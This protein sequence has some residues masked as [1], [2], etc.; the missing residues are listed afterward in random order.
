MH[1]PILKICVRTKWKFAILGIQTNAHAIEMLNTI[2]NQ[3]DM[4]NLPKINEID[5]RGDKHFDW[6]EC[7]VTFHF[8]ECLH[9]MALPSKKTNNVKYEKA[10][11]RYEIST[12]FI[13]KLNDSFPLKEMPP[14]NLMWTLWLFIIVSCFTAIKMN[15]SSIKIVAKSWFK[16]IKSHPKNSCMLSNVAYFWWIY[17]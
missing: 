9:K 15:H 5:W 3:F 7:E 17:N 11:N 16:P 1:S 10:I 14:I 8:R 2:L 6:T 12:H 4:H 13:L